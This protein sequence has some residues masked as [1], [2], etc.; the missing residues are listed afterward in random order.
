M[1]PIRSILT[2]IAIA[3]ALPA[4]VSDIDSYEDLEDYEAYE[5]GEALG[6]AE[7]E[8]RAPSA[9]LSLSNLSQNPPFTLSCGMATLDFDIDET[10][11]GGAATGQF[12]LRAEELTPS[13]WRIAG[14]VQQPS[15]AANSVTQQTGVQISVY[16]GP[17]DITICTPE[18]KTY[19]LRA[20]GE[21]IGSDGG[22]TIGMLN[23]TRSCPGP[24]T[25]AEPA[26]MLL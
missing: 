20:L 17:C 4:C 22:P 6:A 3:C 25:V 8:L 12:V 11:S 16:T 7:S 1:R 15:V 14:A 13:G 2:V 18:T 23:L 5:N 19:Q 21:G 10:N 24:A 26:A 9:L